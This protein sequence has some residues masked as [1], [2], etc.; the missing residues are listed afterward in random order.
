MTGIHDGESKSKRKVMD[1]GCKVG[2]HDSGSDDRN[3]V[4]GK[5]REL[6]VM[7]WDRGRSGLLWRVSA[8]C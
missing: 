6:G 3:N 4:V 5:E 1:I 2:L 8:G 7:H